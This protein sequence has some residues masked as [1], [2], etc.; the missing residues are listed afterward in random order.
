MREAAE[1]F[2]TAAGRRLR[3][4]R[5][6]TWTTDDPVLVLLHEGL[7]S[8]GQWHAFPDRLADA[9]G[10]PALAYD[11][12]GHGGSEPLAGPRPS[13]FLD[14]EAN[15]ALPDLLAACGVG[16]PVLFGHSD[17]G[18]I[19]LLFAA[20]FPDVPVAV[21][22]EAAHVMMEDFTRASLLDLRER[23]ASDASFRRRLARH[24]GDGTEAMFRGFAETWTRPELA[25]WQMLDR[26][27]A[28][29]CP[30]LALQGEDDE[31]G[32][33]AQVEEIVSR[34]SGAARGLMIPACGHSPHREHEDVVLEKTAAFVRAVLAGR[35]DEPR[36]VATR[37]TPS[38]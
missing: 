30:V 7:G 31:H 24:H 20:A 36:R 34:V 12:Y 37:R 29:R 6:G 9:C 16:R 38:H 11:R 19:A 18:T 13:H 8:I 27:P 25:G 14:L 17:G 35:E 28:I 10:L 4:R 15:E 5:I 2:I 26:L 32:T 21:V 22:A 1:A 3:V 33:R 23:W